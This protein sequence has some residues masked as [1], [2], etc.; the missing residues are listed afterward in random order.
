MSDAASDKHAGSEKVA[1]L[2]TADSVPEIDPVAQKRL[3]R[4]TD[5]ILMPILCMSALSRCILYKNEM[6]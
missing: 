5:L 4:K 6:Y 3:V 2:G 1:E